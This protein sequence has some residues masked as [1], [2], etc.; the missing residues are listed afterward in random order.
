[1][2]EE[3]LDGFEEK[4]IEILAADATSSDRKLL[5]PEIESLSKDEAFY[6]HII[7]YLTGL[8]I[9]E[10]E[11]RQMWSSILEHKYLM[12]E[13]LGRNIGIRV[14]ALDYF[15]NIDKRL[16]FVTFVDIN[17]LKKISTG[18]VYDSLTRVYRKDVMDEKISG[19]LAEALAGKKKFTLIFFDVDGFKKYNDSLG[20]LAG[21]TALYEIARGMRKFSKNI[22]RFGGDEFVIGEFLDLSG[23]RDLAEDIIKE[24]NKTSFVPEDSDITMNLSYGTASFPEDGK[25]LPALL[26]AADKRLYEAKGKLKR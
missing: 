20:H 24:I 6:S 5:G 26:A 13:K 10:R 18:A 22:F 9:K 23:A 15:M 8:Y 19:Y 11:S 12:S 16:K 25:D 4:A 7:H 2:I 3:E 21:D 1:M 14:A 17:K